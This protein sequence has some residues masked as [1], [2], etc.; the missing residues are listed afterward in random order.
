MRSAKGVRALIK[1]GLDNQPLSL[2]VAV[3]DSH[4]ASTFRPLKLDLQFAVAKNRN[5]VESLQKQH[6]QWNG[7]KQLLQNRPGDAGIN[8]V[9]AKPRAHFALS[10]HCPREDKASAR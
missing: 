3:C 10:V 7:L 6:R 2:C 9:H 1:T 4:A 8:R 5:A